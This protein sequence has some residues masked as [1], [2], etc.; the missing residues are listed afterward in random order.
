[1]RTATRFCL[2]RL[3][4]L[5]RAIRA[6]SYPNARTMARS[7]EVSPRTVHRD[8]EFLRDR[9]GAPL[10]FDRVRNGYAYRD[11]C[12][13]LPVLNLTEGELIAMLVSEQVLEQYQGTPYARDAARAFQKITVGLREPVTIDL[14]HFGRVQSFRTTA[15][16]KLDPQLFQT[17][18]SAIRD[19]RR[20]AVHY[21]SACRDI[22]T[23]RELDPYHLASIDGQW[24]L[25]GYCH[26]RQEVR[27]FVPARIRSAEVTEVTFEVPGSFRIDEYLRWSF[28]VLRGHEDA[29]YQVRLRFTGAAVKYVRE[30]VWHPSQVLEPD[31]DN[32]LVMRLKLS[33]LREI[34]RWA[35]SWGD[36]CEVLEPAELRERVTA[37]LAR[38]RALYP[39]R[40]RLT[41][42]MLSDPLAPRGSRSDP[43]R[44]SHSA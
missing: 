44:R 20:L 9:L 30:R 13:A 35:L 11:A 40:T 5:D 14:S 25:I 38:A 36:E 8:I 16:T 18:L 39:D 3:A 41:D 23:V 31:G 7:L 15:S 34:Q 12:F 24:Y 29:L 1:M 17:L 28:S 27:M 33:H 37:D 43:V 4:A 22:E 21:W 10:V 19:R 26:F 2:E 32:G 6:G 42:P